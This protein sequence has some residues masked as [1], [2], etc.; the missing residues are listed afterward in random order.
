MANLQKIRSGHLGRIYN[1]RWHKSGTNPRKV[2]EKT[3][4]NGME[5]NKQKVSTLQKKNLEKEKYNG[6]KI[7]T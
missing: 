6:S 2:K 5:E 7:D 4:S 3:R 1:R